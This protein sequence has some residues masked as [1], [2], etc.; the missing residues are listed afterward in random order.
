MTT[1]TKPHAQYIAGTWKL[2]PTHSRISFT[3]RHLMISKVRGTFD[4]FDVTVVTAENPKDSTI[5][6]VIDVA[7]VNTG[8]ADRDNHLRTSDFFLVEKYPKATFT[9]TSFT[10]DGDRFTVH[11]DLTLRGVTRPVVLTGELGGVIVDGYG[12]TRAGATASTTINRHDFGVSWNAALEA[13]GMTLGDDIT[14]DF[15]LQVVLQS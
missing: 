11:G 15:D 13:G 14:I 10:I 12:L 9:S 2:D 7:S 5:E 6:A 3:V 1:T 4:S 8:Q